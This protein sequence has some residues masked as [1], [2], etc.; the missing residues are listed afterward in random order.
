MRD[1]G[2]RYLSACILAVHRL[3]SHQGVMPD[4]YKPPYAFST[5]IGTVCAQKSRTFHDLAERLCME[6][7]WSIMRG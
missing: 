2:T 3:A 5:H 6:L 4:K 7:T 1:I